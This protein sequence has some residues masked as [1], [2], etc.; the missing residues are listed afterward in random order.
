MS[1]SSSRR[2]TM[3]T[4]R[5]HVRGIPILGTSKLVWWDREA[6]HITTQRG[7]LSVKIM[8]L[9]LGPSIL[10][11]LLRHKYTYTSSV[12]WKGHCHRNESHSWLSPQPWTLELSHNFLNLLSCMH[13][14]YGCVYRLCGSS[15]GE[16]AVGAIFCRL[17][18]CAKL[19][20][21]LTRCDARKRAVAVI[22]FLSFVS[23]EF[24][25]L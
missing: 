14:V 21:W 13:R 2:R 24:R 4:E 9:R 5:L 20:G 15:T 12:Y 11:Y 3:S 6:Y 25:H 16:S 1:L 19:K 23:P 7:M 8:H 10:S 17:Y 18:G 22:I